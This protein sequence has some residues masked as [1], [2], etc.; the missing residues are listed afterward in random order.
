MLA[1]LLNDLSALPNDVVLVLD[2]YHV[3][4]AP[5]VH[6]GMSFLLE[7]LPPQVHVVMTTR[8][9]PPLPL[10]RLRARGELVEI[11][12]ADLRFTPEEATGVPQRGDGSEPDG[13]GCRRAGRAY[14]RLDRRAP[15]GGALDPGA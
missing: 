1:T 7:H 13:A 5:D 2:D 15:A 3:I 9:D 6:E 8:A 10:A 12:A 4:D 11:R 14:R